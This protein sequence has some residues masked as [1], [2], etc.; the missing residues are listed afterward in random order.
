MAG[1]KSVQTERITKLIA[2]S[3]FTQLVQGIPVLI[4]SMDVWGLDR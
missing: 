3:V 4:I 1:P 2:I